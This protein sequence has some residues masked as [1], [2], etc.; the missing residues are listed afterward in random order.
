MTFGAWLASGLAGGSAVDTEDAVEDH[1]GQQHDG[2]DGEG[3]LSEPAHE[4]AIAKSGRRSFWLASAIAS[5][6]S[7][8]RSV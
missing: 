6:A 2:D 8:T 4:G 3:G 1:A 7:P 5:T